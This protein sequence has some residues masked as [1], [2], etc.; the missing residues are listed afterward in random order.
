MLVPGARYASEGCRGRPAGRLGRH[1]DA[2]RRRLVRDNGTGV[3]PERLAEIFQLFRHGTPNAAGGSGGLG[4][5][6]AVARQLVEL[7][8]GTIEARSEGIGKGTEFA[9]RLP[10]GRLTHTQ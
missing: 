5:G 10:R 3:A 9:I 6:L 4:V 2:N 8:G 1:C 7:H